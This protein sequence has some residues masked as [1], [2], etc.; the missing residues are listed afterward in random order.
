MTFAHFASRCGRRSS[1]SATGG[2]WRRAGSTLSAPRSPA[3]TSLALEGLVSPLAGL[4]DLWDAPHR[5]GRP[6]GPAPAGTGAGRGQGQ[7]VR[8]PPGP[9]RADRR[10]HGPA[11]GP[12][13]ARPGT[14]REVTVSDI[15]S[16]TVVA[17]FTNRSATRTLILVRGGAVGH[18]CPAD[19]SGD[20]ARCGRSGND[21]GRRGGGGPAASFPHP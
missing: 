15:A 19:R 18:R 11:G 13:P 9:A 5:L 14:D 17:G 7:A 8:L 12:L 10:L 1:G 4:E 3:A 20:P 6:T 2:S 16:R 21:A